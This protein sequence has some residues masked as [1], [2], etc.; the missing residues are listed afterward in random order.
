MTKW[1]FIYK[2]IYLILVLLLSF[3]T[4]QGEPG[5]FYSESHA[6]HAK[7]QVSDNAFFTYYVNSN[8]EILI[9]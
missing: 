6:F 5:R 9:S 8:H 1:N 3:C 7:L 4:S 2:N